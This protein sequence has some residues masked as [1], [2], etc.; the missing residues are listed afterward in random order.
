M[1]EE[2][3][4]EKAAAATEHA[5]TGAG[6]GNSGSSKLVLILTAVNLVAVIGMGAVLFISFKNTKAP[7]SVEDISEEEETAGHAAADSHGGGGGHGAPAKSGGHGGGHGAAAEKKA[8]SHAGAVMSLEQFT[9]N[10]STP[11]T[12][13]PVFVRVNISV[14][15]QSGD[16]EQEISQRMPQVRNAII[17]LFNSKR[18]SDLATVEGRE[19]LKEEIKNAINHFL[20]TGKIKGVFFTNFTVTG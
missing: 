5:S 20:V 9:V 3:K 16:T 6:G 1:A 7:A 19:L 18:A 17:D 2:A 4:P 12:N 13:H 15:V 11:G 8:L 10:L 14:E